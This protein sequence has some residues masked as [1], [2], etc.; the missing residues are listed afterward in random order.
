MYPV[1]ALLMARAA[2]IAWVQLSLT[3][4]EFIYDLIEDELDRHGALS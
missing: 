2:I 1:F 4:T 3:P